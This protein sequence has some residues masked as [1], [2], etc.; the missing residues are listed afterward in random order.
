MKTAKDA[1]VA[2]P[3]SQHHAHQKLSTGIEHDQTGPQSY[4]RGQDE[5]GQAGVMTGALGITVT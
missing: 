1:T 3:S 2:A 4:A 5:P